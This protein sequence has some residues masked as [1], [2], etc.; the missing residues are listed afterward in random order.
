MS[1]KTFNAVFG[2]GCFV[3]RGIHI[4]V[5]ADIGENDLCVCM[6]QYDSKTLS[7]DICIIWTSSGGDDLCIVALVVGWGNK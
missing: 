6:W 3:S 5:C 7:P 2:E 1:G 4:F